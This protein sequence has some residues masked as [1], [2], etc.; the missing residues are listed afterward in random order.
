[1]ATGGFFEQEQVGTDQQE[2]GQPQAHL[3]AA[4]K[5]VG[6]TVQVVARKTQTIEHG[7]GLGVHRITV[8]VLE[9]SFRR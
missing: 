6:G 9:F 1:M 2:L 5:F 7:G 3:P 8:A 4:G